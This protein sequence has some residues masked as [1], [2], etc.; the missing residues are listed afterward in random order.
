[1]PQPPDHPLG[2]TPHLRTP[3]AYPVLESRQRHRVDAQHGGSPTFLR[4]A[5]NNHDHDHDHR[6]K[7]IST[8]CAMASMQAAM[9]AFVAADLM[10]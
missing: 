10:I 2:P 5:A 1:M 4:C 8:R 3:Q 6:L 9:W 7:L